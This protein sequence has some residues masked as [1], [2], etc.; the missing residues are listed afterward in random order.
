MENAIKR[1]L[2]A[3]EA[4]EKKRQ[5]KLAKGLPSTAPTPPLTVPGTPHSH[6]RRPSQEALRTATDAETQ[7]QGQ[8]IE[9]RELAVDPEKNEVVV[10]RRRWFGLLPAKKMDESIEKVRPSI[11]DINPLPTMWSLLK[12][13]SNLII[14][15]S[16]GALLLIIDDLALMNRITI[17]CSVHHPLYRSRY[18]CSVSYSLRRGYGRGLMTV[19]YTT[20]TRFMSVSSFSRLALDQS[21][22]LLLAVNCRTWFCVV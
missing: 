22:G 14:L 15:C 8:G 5:R 18:P 4:K 9:Q 3:D 16:S 6:S 13:P 19:N 20:I 10:T 21:S 12:V 11:R 2:H 1:A 17:C 7:E